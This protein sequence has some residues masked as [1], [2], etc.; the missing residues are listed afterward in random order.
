M[1]KAIPALKSLSAYFQAVPVS[2]T[3]WDVNPKKLGFLLKTRIHPDRSGSCKCWPGTLS[4]SSA[5]G[6]RRGLWYPQADPSPYQ[7]WRRRRPICNHGLYGTDPE[8]G[9]TDIT[10]HRLCLQGRRIS[11]YFVPGRH[12]DVFRQ[13]AEKPVNRCRSPSVSALTRPS[14]SPPA[15]NHLQLHSAS[16]NWA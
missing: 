4:G 3:C 11:M 5:S 10:I 1:L 7:Y 15:S 6:N 2:G 8:T 9:D 16:M 12:L 14:R 13:N